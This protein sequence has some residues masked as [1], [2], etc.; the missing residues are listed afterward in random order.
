M[1]G[2]FKERAFRSLSPGLPAWRLTWPP[3]W[4]MA[5]STLPEEIQTVRREVAITSDRAPPEPGGTRTPWSWARPSI[6]PSTTVVSRLKIESYRFYNRS[7]P[8]TTSIVGALLAIRLSAPPSSRASWMS[9]S[10]RRCYAWCPPM[11]DLELL[12][13]EV[14]P[15]L[16]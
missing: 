2:R 8:A 1:S 15:L 9:G 14:L 3:P 12:H 10:Q 13:R 5:G 16:K 6:F 11:S 7:I 4:P